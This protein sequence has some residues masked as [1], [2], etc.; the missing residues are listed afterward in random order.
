[1]RRVCVVMGV[2]L[3][4]VVPAVP[5]HAGTTGILVF[6]VFSRSDAKAGLHTMPAT[7]G[8]ETKLA[9][10]TSAYRPRWAPD[11]SGLAYIHAR[12][13]RWIDADGSN[14]H[15]LVGHAA[16][17]AHHDFPSTIAWSP[18]GKQLL[19]PLYS[20]GFRTVRLYRV[21]IATKR[22]HVVLKG[23]YDADWSTA[24]RIVAVKAGT[25]MTMDPDG[26]NRTVISTHD[27]TWLRWSPDA[28]MLVLQRNLNSG[29]DIFVMGSDGSNP[30][31]ITNSKSF[32][33]W[34]SWSPDSSRI[35]WSKSRDISSPGNFFAMD[36]DG[37]NV[38]QLTATPK[39]DEYE[40]DWA[41]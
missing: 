24:N 32:D 16:M 9:G 38:T 20:S 31:N 4:L 29:G 8:T 21:N 1:M 22:F 26:S 40:P 5:G 7:G 27:A 28:S 19:L 13:I 10:T 33:W 18:D 36:P 34:P 25:I 37:S 23:A 14:D 15:V 17:P 11:G 39:L 30:T 2:I 6:S 12:S 41:A 3:A 35:V